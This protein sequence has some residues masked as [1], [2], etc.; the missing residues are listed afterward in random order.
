MAWWDFLSIHC[1][2]CDRT[3]KLIDGS[4]DEYVMWCV[5]CGVMLRANVHDPISATDWHIPKYHDSSY[6]IRK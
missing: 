5:D 1:V 4:T 6:D 2:V 3:L